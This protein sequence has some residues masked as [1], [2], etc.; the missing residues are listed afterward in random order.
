[1]AFR[2]LQKGREQL[3]PRFASLVCPTVVM[4][5]T[6]NGDAPR[7]PVVAPQPA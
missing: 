6:R 3:G 7:H 4:G 5:S 1:V 2:A